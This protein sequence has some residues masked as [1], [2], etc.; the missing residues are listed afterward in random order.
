MVSMTDCSAAV[1][2]PLRGQTTTTQIRLCGLTWPER[3]LLNATIAVSITI[4]VINSL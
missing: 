1:A 2:Q 4:D 3:A